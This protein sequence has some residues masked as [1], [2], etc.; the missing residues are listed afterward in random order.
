MIKLTSKKLTNILF[1]FQIKTLNVSD[2]IHYIRD[3]T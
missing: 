3:F 2:H 1:F